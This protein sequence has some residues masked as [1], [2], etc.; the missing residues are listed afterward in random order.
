MSISRIFIPNFACVLT[1]ERSKTHQT[2][3]GFCRTDH[4]IMVRLGGAL[5]SKIKF[6]PSF[7]YA[8][9]SWTIWQ[10]STKLGV[11]VTHLNGASNSTFFCPVP[12]GPGKGSKGQISLNFNYKEF[13]TKLC[14]CS[15]YYRYKTYQT[16][17]LFCGLGH[18]PGWDF[19]CWDIKTFSMG[20]AMASHRLLILGFV[21]NDSLLS[22]NKQC[23][24]AAVRSTI[25]LF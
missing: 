12:W 1:N 19:V 16:E 15:H 14:A 24:H 20:F 18:V 13:Y 11:W 8:F 6:R 23:I 10:N 2:G 5:M 3:I 25:R 4:A 21:Y 9:S 7:R 17:F 22:L